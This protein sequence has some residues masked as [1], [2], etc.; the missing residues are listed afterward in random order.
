M[1]QVRAR[2]KCGVEVSDRFQGANTAPPETG[3]R[4]DAIRPRPAAPGMPGWWWLSSRSLTWPWRR[5]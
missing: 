1:A 5:Y 3:W 2:L 4:W